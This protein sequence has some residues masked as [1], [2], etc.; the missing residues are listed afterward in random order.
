MATKKQIQAARLFLEAIGIKAGTLKESGRQTV[1]FYVTS[2]PNELMKQLDRKT[3]TPDG[4]SG[5]AKH[6]N[7][8]PHK[9]LFGE[10][11]NST[12]HRQLDGCWYPGGGTDKKQPVIYTSG[13]TPTKS[14]ITL[15]NEDQ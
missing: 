11:F 14:T 4:P 15:C 2:G 10:T 7:R 12:V 13:I 3:V 8:P 6:M 9:L 1:T 5:L